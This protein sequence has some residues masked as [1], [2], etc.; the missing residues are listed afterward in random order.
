MMLIN[1]IVSFSFAA[2]LRTTW[3]QGLQNYTSLVVVLALCAYTAK[4]SRRQINR[5]ITVTH[6]S[7]SVLESRSLTESRRIRALASL[8]RCMHRMH[9]KCATRPLVPSQSLI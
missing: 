6:E 7:L 5:V 4:N 1:K 9:A 2:A 3:A 8:H